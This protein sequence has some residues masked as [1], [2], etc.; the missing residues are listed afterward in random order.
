M[1]YYE[2]SRRMIIFITLLNS[3]SY[4]TI[5]KLK[6]KMLSFENFAVLKLFFNA[7]DWSSN[8]N[9]KYNKRGY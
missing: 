6:R 5:V 2:S 7:L 1:L 9:L 3:I 4:L 8:Q